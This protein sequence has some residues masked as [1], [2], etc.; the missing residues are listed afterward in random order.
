LKTKNGKYLYEKELLQSN[1][2][3]NIKGLK[4][5]YTYTLKIY[6][7]KKEIFEVRQTIFEKKIR[8]YSYNSLPKRYFN[9]EKVF[10]GENLDKLKE[11]K[12]IN[13]FI[14]INK[15]ENKNEYIGQVYQMKNGQPYYMDKV[16]PVKIE[17]ITGIIENKMNVAITGTKGDLEGAGLL[18]DFINKTIYNGDDP[19][20]QDIFEYEIMLERRNEY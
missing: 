15:R 4:S 17:M 5:F 13:T 11:Q 9:I 18:L 7:I 20:K 1:T 6:E 19:N 16:N 3:L 8:V 12:L 14:L 2:S 10:Y